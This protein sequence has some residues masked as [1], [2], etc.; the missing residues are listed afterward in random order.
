MA[1]Q[2]LEQYF[3]RFRRH[4]IGRDEPFTT[5]YGPQRVVY[6][7]WTASARLYAPIEDKIARQLG[8]FVANTHTETTVTGT[9]MTLAYHEA[10]H[11]IKHHVHA[12]P[13]DVMLSVGSGMTAGVVKLQ[14]ILGLKMP[15][16]HRH[17][18][19]IPACERPVVF[20]T[21]MEHHSNHI[22]WLETICD[23][24]IIRATDDG[25]VDLQNFRQLLAQFADRPLKI[26]SVTACSN[27]TGIRPPYEEISRIVHEAGGLCFVDFACS[28]PYVD[29]DM[30][31]AD[32]ACRLDAIFLAPHK[33][34]GGPGSA[35]V[36]VFHSDL[37]QLE[38]PD[39][40]GGGTVTWT[41]AW[42]EMA[43]YDNI[44]QRE[45]GGTPG[46]LQTIR[47]ALAIRLKEEMGV[48]NIIAREHELIAR[49]FA[50]FDTIP[51]V[52]VLQD[53]I[54][55]RM[56]VISFTMQSVHYNLVVKL[57]NDRFGVQTRGGCACAGTYGHFLFYIKRTE[58]R[59]VTD[60]IDH[61][62]L[63]NKPGWVRL[64]IHPTMTDEEVDYV[65]RAV[66]EIARHGQEW[67]ADYTYDA[68]TNEW[69][70]G[71]DPG[72]AAARVKQWFAGVTPAEEDA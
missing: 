62:D 29:I 26:A 16:Q 70:H 13:D 44:E 43:Y 39:R 59:R 36:V 56:G 63:S 23:V 12:G 51:Q 47:V 60:R 21:H 61:G 48:A 66:G 30:H 34:L 25:H 42:N 8:P 19:T 55:D 9:S 18:C 24:V 57:L 28:G 40:P 14:R 58:S 41:N 4:I 52:H 33:F 7:D 2:T 10:Q 46:Y 72:F 38:S 3:A 31:P 6:A 37:Y 53:N 54:R 35:G 20:I 22:T 50:C 49:I 65:C 1:E 15:E 17:R 45:D 27:V 71:S 64:S 67:A 32:P 5:A 69:V 11:I 68:A